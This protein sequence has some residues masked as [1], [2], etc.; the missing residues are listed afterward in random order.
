MIV[1]LQLNASRLVL[2]AILIIYVNIQV[3]I[4]ALN[5]LYKVTEIFIFMYKIF[6]D[7]YIINIAWTCKRYYRTFD[8]D[9]LV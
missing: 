1:S 9:W 8:S 5:N 2:Y 7:K 6:K 3:G 4:K